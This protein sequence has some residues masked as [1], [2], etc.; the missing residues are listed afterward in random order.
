MV[1]IPRDLTA[2]LMSALQR[3]PI[4]T[5]TGP[6]QSG[7]TTLARAKIAKPYANLE[8][9]DVRRF[10]LDDPRGFLAQFPEGAI[11]DE[12]QRTPDL[13]SYLQVDVDA[14]GQNGRWVLTGSHQPA[15]R[16]ALGQSLAGRTALLQL[17]PLSLG[18]WSAWERRAG[19]D[20]LLISGAFPHLHEAHIP[21]HQFHADYIGTYLE[22]DVRQILKVS[23]LGTFQRFLGFFA[24][25]HAQIM[26]YANLG[27]DT[28]INQTTVKTW[29]SV[30]EASH[31]AVPLPPWFANIGKRLTKSPKW[32]LVDSGMAAYLIGCTSVTNLATHPH[33]GHLFEGFVVSE[34]M[35]AIAH[36]ASP[37]RLHLYSSQTSEVDLL[38][39]ANG[40]TLA[41]EIKAGQT[42]A[43]DWFR[44]VA[45][46]AAI[47]EA[48][49]DARMVV[50]GGK[51]EQHRTLGHVCPWWLFPV[52]LC[53]WLAAHDAMPHLTDL[54][55]IEDRLRSCCAG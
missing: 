53:G 23:D 13:L 52:R 4:V 9:P 28:G 19:C 2:S 48:A 51:E 8:A 16:A 6:R 46:V 37:A 14:V 55:V 40:R 44:N 10:A 3:Y 39:E 26:N 54:S 50:Y 33:R 18:E 25:R 35:K 32:Y 49:V 38:I 20:D 41:V 42:I 31:V 47:P 11:L 29:C 7:T 5:I 43:D 15:L 24:G 34:A 12:I 17:L 36:A 27:A 1:E 45:E 30:L 22:R 21:P